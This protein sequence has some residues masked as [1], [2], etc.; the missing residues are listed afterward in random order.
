MHRPTAD[1]PDMDEA[2]GQS[3]P[4]LAPLPQPS[5]DDRGLVQGLVGDGRPLLMFV[6]LALVLSGGFAIF[7]AATGHFLPHDERFLGMTARDLCS[8]HGC[9]IVHFMYHD[10]GAFGGS[11]IAIGTLYLWL[12]AFPLR[13]R[14]PWAWWTLLLTGTLG[15]ASFLTYLGY[16]YL[17][18]WH[19]AATLLLL[20]CFVWGM[21]R[22]YHTLRPPRHIRSLLQPAVTVRWSSPVGVGRACLLVTSAT[23]VAGGL[24]IMTVGMT[25]VF[26]PEDLKF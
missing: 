21:A 4:T 15:F 24:V 22:T 7:L 18:T 14:E 6:G 1:A 5:H 9:R 13:E 17:D 23:L 19:G 10:R 26:V 20:P 16:G 8:L 25:S 2:A 12:A 11:I 3:S